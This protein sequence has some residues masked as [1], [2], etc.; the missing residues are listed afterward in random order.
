MTIVSEFYDGP[1]GRMTMLADESGLAGLYFRNH[2]HPTPQAPA[3]VVAVFDKTKRQLDE[4]FAGKRSSFDLPLTMRG[5]QFQRDVWDWLLKIPHG[6]TRTY[7]W[8]AKQLE[9]PDAARAVGAAV[10]QNRIS[11]IVPCHR[12]IG[13]NGSLTGFA[14]GLENKKY[15]LR[16]EGLLLV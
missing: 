8:I 2:K 1:T 10:G 9:L 13:A 11:I 14:G 3:G 16:L 6:E 4:Y 7:G 15:L 12:V 5:T